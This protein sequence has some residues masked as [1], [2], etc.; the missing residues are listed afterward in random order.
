VQ[1][2]RFWGTLFLRG[3]DPPGGPASRRRCVRRPIAMGV[4]TAEQGTSAKTSNIAMYGYGRLLGQPEVEFF[5][6]RP[7]KKIFRRSRFALA[8]PRR[9]RRLGLRHLRPAAHLVPYRRRPSGRII[10][11]DIS[12]DRHFRVSDNR[13][14]CRSVELASPRPTGQVISVGNVGNRHSD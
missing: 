1:K 9:L 5:G 11:A 14:L 10:S 3:P 4:D 12:A 8:T 6:P 2:T 7:L 13:G